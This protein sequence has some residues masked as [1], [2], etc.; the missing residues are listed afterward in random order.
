ME[1]VFLTSGRP[2][3]AVARFTGS[4]IDMPLTWGSAALHP[5]LYAFARS[6]G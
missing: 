5:R 2:V 4:G 3:P 6:A 1:E